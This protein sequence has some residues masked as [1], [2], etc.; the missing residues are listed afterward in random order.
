[1]ASTTHND[2]TAARANEG[3]A[4]SLQRTHSLSP[5]HAGKGQEATGKRVLSSCASNFR[6]QEDDSR[7]N[8]HYKPLSHFGPARA[9]R[10]R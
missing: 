4:E 6:S 9:G 8:L 7:R 1:M 3:K 5:G 2:V 10:L